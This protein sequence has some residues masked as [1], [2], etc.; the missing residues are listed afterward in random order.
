MQPRNTAKTLKHTISANFKIYNEM[1]AKEWALHP[2]KIPT[3]YA[4]WFENIDMDFLSGKD[5]RNF[6]DA[7]HLTWHEHQSGNFAQLISSAIHSTRYGGFSH[8]GGISILKKVEEARK[9]MIAIN[10]IYGGQYS[11]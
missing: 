2:E 8:L 9:I 3:E 10:G 5:I 6:M 11:V 1:L 4:A 7:Y